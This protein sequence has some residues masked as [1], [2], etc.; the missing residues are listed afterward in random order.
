M[1]ETE[2]APVPDGG[3][4]R[5]E[6]QK[7]DMDALQAAI[8][9]RVE[10]AEASAKADVARRLAEPLAAIVNRLSDKDAIFRDSLIGNLREICDLMPAL[11][12]TGDAKL[13]A[14]CKRIRAELYHTDANLCRE[15]ST[16]RGTHPQI[17]AG[18]RGPRVH[19]GGADMGHG[20]RQKSL[21]LLRKFPTVGNFASAAPTLRIREAGQR[22]SARKPPSS[23]CVAGTLTVPAIARRLL[24][25]V[26]VIKSCPGC[27]ARFSGTPPSVTKTS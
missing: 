19:L 25:F 10:K 11:N 4:L 23:S 27:S 8:E 24:R 21:F 6:L 13:E 26:L 20:K 2:F 18:Q 17:H 3:D 22:S 9:S 15:N 14:A 7:E 5:I 12:I 16:V 1:F